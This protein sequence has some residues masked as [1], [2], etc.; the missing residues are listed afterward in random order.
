MNDEADIEAAA[1]TGSL[2]GATKS[3]LFAFARERQAARPDAAPAPKFDAVHALCH[4]GALIAIGAM[5]VFTTVAIGGLAL[6]VMAVLYA[7]GFLQRQR[8]A[9]T[10]FV[11]GVMPEPLRALRPARALIL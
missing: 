2:D 1:E 11:A 3:R 9:I 4:A 5:G 7:A 6:A 10:A 8:R